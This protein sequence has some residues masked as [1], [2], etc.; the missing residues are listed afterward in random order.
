MF[1]IIK[2][3]EYIQTSKPEKQIGDEIPKGVLKGN[4]NRLYHHNDL[5][6]T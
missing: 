5:Y 1:I 4:T 3:P 6:G 2:F